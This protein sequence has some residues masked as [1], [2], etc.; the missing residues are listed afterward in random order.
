MDPTEIADKLLSRA[1]GEGGPRTP[2]PEST[3]RLQFHAG[4]TFRDAIAIT[5]YLSELGVT[6]CYASPYLTARPGSTHGYDIVDHGSLNPEIGTA[7]D[8]DEWVNALH[9]HGLGQILDTVP[10]HMAVG[11]NDNPWWNDVLENGPASRYAA[12]FDIAWRSSLRPEL[13]DKVL[14]PVLAD[15]Y[16]DVLEAGQITLVYV[17][18]SFSVDY[19]SRRFPIAPRSYDRILGHTLEELELSLA[20]EDPCLI[21]LKSVLTAVRNLPGSSETEPDRVSERQREKE[22]IK[23]RL[24]ALAGQSQPIREWIDRKVA[25]FNGTPGDPANFELMDDLLEHQCYRLSYWR[26]G[27][28]EINYRRFFDVNDLAALAVEREEVFEATHA[29]I[30]RLVADDKVDG[31]RIDHPDGLF[32]PAT[33]FRRLQDHT[34]VAR[35]RKA[36]EAEFEPDTV[37]WNDVERQIRD[38]LAA[39]NVQ[40]G[41]QSHVDLPLYVAVE[42]ILGSREQLVSAWP[43]HGTSGY[44]FINQ[45]NGLFVDNCQVTRLSRLY[46]EIVPD[47]VPFLELVYRK[48]LLIVQVSLAS[49]LHM[50]T[51]QLD[52]LAQKSRRSRDFTFNSLRDSLREVIAC[53]PVYRSY[54]D[55]AGASPTDRHYVESAVRMARIRNPLLTGRIF[56]FIRDMILGDCPGI[57]SADDRALQQRFAGKFQ[58]V[59]APVMAKGVEDTAFYVDQ[60]LISLN[61]VG[62]DPARFGVRLEALHAFN[63]EKQRDWPF[64]LCPLSTHDTKRSEDVRARI[65]VLSEIPD[66]WGA[67]V[68]RYRELNRPHLQQVGDQTAPDVNEEYLLYQTLIG[69]WPLEPYS[70]DDYSSF[71]TR[72]QA[73]MEKALHEAKV[74]SSW[75]NP[76]PDYDAAVR[77]FVGLIL[78]D[79]QSG[80]FLTEFRTL[81][82]RV[83]QY[84]VFN[85]LSQ[86]LLKLTSPGVADTYQGT[87]LWEFSL[88][89]P[90]NRRPVNYRVRQ[91]ILREFRSSAVNSDDARQFCRDL[92][93][94]RADGRIKLYVHDKTLNL[95]KRMPGLFTA[96]EYI[97]LSV[98]G[99]CADHVIAFARRL[100]DSVAIVTVPRL[101]VRL[102]PDPDQPPLGERV[103]Q[104]T[105]LVLPAEIRDRDWRNL[106]SG[107]R[108]VASQ[109]DGRPSLAA[110]TVFAHFPVAVLLS[111]RDT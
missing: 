25:V 71:V 4:F 56:R 61:E 23:R 87:E 37:G 75:I 36:F 59:T 76:D 51:H 106:F 97:P 105:R 91:E 27:S 64:A 35:A 72:V 40:R 1:L 62:G 103:W 43:V 68:E 77:R 74:H 66:Q 8:Y 13:G 10:N 28:D 32:D 96:G 3:Y 12:Y 2:L 90:D 16:G 81:A 45:V 50:L 15:L 7:L 83:S 63:Q 94:N 24:A 110:A 65:N 100:G 48:K 54:V 102:I 9:G 109:C 104:D 88:V 31:L 89:D 70:A 22:V 108:A 55:S 69:A 99:S 98:A 49:E 34:V 30:F 33:Y 95:R 5:P 53:F 14:L 57:D 73:Y 85:S 46:R 92:I 18:G 78:D 19:A 6:H 41:A 38:R 101:F 20:A 111:G 86:T 26:V 52:R 80:P 47:A 82:R 21:E 107:E 44:D 39:H 84:G 11:T 17:D 79:Q 42:K 60:R 93:A 67:A 29:L 58:Q